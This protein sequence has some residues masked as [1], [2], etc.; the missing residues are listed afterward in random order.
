M[1]MS[2]TIQEVQTE[3]HHKQPDLS[4]PHVCCCGNAR[5]FFSQPDYVGVG[6]VHARGVSLPQVIRRHV[7]V[8]PVVGY[9]RD[10]L[11]VIARQHSNH[12]LPPFRMK[13]YAIADLELQHL[14]MRAHLV[15]ESQS[16]NY[17]V[18]EVYELCFA[19]FAD[20][21]LHCFTYLFNSRYKCTVM[22]L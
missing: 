5:S 6:N 15:E 21:D 19:Q 11:P 10:S 9:D 22:L 7:P 1:Q 12:R 13:S 16:F 8:L 2:Q 4:N 14:R 3:Y 20:I 18:V 17:P